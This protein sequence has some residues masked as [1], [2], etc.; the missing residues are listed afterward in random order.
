MKLASIIK[1]DFAFSNLMHSALVSISGN[2]DKMFIH[3]QLINSFIRKLFGVEH[4]RFYNCNGEIQL[5]EARHV[6]VHQIA[7]LIN[8]KIK[9]QLKM[10]NENPLRL[11]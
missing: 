11:V 3:V 9:E 6:F 1:I 4:I 5:K 10:N 8:S 7:Q 2:E